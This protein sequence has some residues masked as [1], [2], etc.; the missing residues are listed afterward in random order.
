MNIFPG[1]Y[2]VIGGDVLQMINFSE[3]WKHLHFGWFSGRVSLFYALF[4]PLEA[5]GISPAGQLSWYLGIF[6]VGAYSSFYFF[7]RSIFQKLETRSASLLALFYALNLYTLYIF[8]ATWGFTSFQILYIFV[9]LLT[10]LYIKAVQETGKKFLFLFLLTAFLVSISFSNPAFALSLALYFLLLTLAFSLFRVFLWNY[11][12]LKRV[13]ILFLGALLLNAYWIL[14]LVPQVRGGVDELSNSTEINLALRLEKTSNAI[15]D[16]IRLLPTSEQNRY[17]PVN[18]PYPSFGWLEDVVIGIAFAPFFLILVGLFLRKAPSERSFYGAFFGLF[19][20]FI[21][22]V[23]R[24]RF[25]FDTLNSFLFELPVLNALRGWEKLAL[26]T[27]FLLSVLLTLFFLNMQ[28]KKHAKIVTLCFSFLAFLLALPFFF[29]GIQTELSYILSGN[30]KKDF[31]TSEFSALVKIPDSYI[32][33]EN[34]FVSDPT[35]SK[36]SMLPYAPGSSVGR[37]SL[38]GLKINGP[39]PAV[40][41]YSKKYVEPN[42]YYFP[43][44]DFGEELNDRSLDPEWIVDLYGLIGIRYVL[45][46]HDVKPKLLV[47]FEPILTYLE[48]EGFLKKR[49]GFPEVDLYEVAEN[50][51][52]PYVYTS[53]TAPALRFSP[54]A[55]QEQVPI[56]KKGV[57]EA[58]YTLLNPKKIEIPHDE[59]SKNQYIFL[60]E[61]YDSLWKAEYIRDTGESILLRRQDEVRYANAWHKEGLPLSTGKIV[62]TYIPADLLKIGIFISGISLIVVL[63]GLGRIYRKRRH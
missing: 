32:Q 45:Y 12:L 53:N 15:I 19:V 36:I 30:K 23:A 9:P 14:P 51:V 27:P 11:I 17:Y 43:K 24:V 31:H 57:E 46:P 62:I 21:A 37:V 52:F 42:D 6:L 50:K 40:V 39:H 47:E 7:C 1:G 48:S 61:R 16:T 59:I 26:F 55:L 60:N 25:P 29:G 20:I 5:M 22:L 8:T 34:V 44:W 28:G 18:F 58:R 10:A 38:P 3:Q 41:L 2:M 49:V 63:A 54:Q 13:A 33:L 35:A 56:L 4:F